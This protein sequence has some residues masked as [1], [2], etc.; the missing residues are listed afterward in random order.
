MS[1]RI[2]RPDDWRVSEPMVWRQLES[3]G[4]SPSDDSGGQTAGKAQ[5]AALEREFEERVRAA[6]SAGFA[7][8]EISGRNRATAEV[9]PVVERL[10]RSIDEVRQLRSRLRQEAEGDLLKLALAIAQR[11]LR[12]EMVVD[13][14]AMHGLVLG[15]LEKLQGQE[16]CRVKTHPSHATALRSWLTSG[17]ASGGGPVEVI[18]D[19]SCVPG[20][21]VFE[22]ERGN[23]DASVDSQLREI[24]RG[25]ADRLRRAL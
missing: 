2:V 5:S 15:A 11:V 7:E 9:Q 19:S 20:D 3:A 12:R 17:G 24:E 4:V 8:G 16:I 21:I 6:R 25:L 23:L 22:T 1:S 14:E 18:A 10:A 13:P